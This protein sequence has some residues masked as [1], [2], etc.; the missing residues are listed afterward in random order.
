MTGAAAV[1]SPLFA[2]FGHAAMFELSPFCA[3]KRTCNLQSRSALALANVPPYHHRTSDTSDQRGPMERNR[4]PRYC[5][6]FGNPPQLLRT[7]RQ[8]SMHLANATHCRVWVGVEIRNRQDAQ[9]DQ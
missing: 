7:R 1:I 9:F 5:D 2:R 4:V 8:E 6:P 3:A